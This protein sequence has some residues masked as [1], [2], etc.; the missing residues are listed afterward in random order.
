MKNLI[1]EKETKEEE[2]KD[3]KE[4]IWKEEIGRRTIR[5]G[6]KEEHVCGRK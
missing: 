1:N 6:E 4:W 2:E 5:E 3:V